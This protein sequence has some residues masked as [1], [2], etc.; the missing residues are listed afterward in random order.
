VGK[1]IWNARLEKA[2]E[3]FRTL[4]NFDKLY[5]GGGNAEEVTLKHDD[6]EVVSNTLGL[7]GGIWLWKDCDLSDGVQK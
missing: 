3:H 5:L 4:T 1:R 2:I 6:I 7:R